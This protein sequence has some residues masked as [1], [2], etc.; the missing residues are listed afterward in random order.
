MDKIVSPAAGEA[1]CSRP[2]RSTAGLAPWADSMATTAFFMKDNVKARWLE[3]M[4]RERDDILALDSPIIL[5][6]KGWEAS[7]HVEGF[8]DP[9]VDCRTCKQRF[10]AESLRELRRGGALRQAVEPVPSKEPRP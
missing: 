10:R 8:T 3:A 4:V 6:P 9:L 2:R 1:S 7:G 5:H